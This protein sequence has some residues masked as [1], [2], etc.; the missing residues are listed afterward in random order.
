M[1]ALHDT[2]IFGV[3]CG[4]CGLGLQDVNAIVDQETV[5]IRGF[6]FQNLDVV[7][8]LETV[9]LAWFS[10]VWFGGSGDVVL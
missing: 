7:V 6:G 1:V 10:G 2:L 4:A 3:S 9:E 5:G 8:D